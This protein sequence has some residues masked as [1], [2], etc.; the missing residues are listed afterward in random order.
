MW[1]ML[2][3]LVFKKVSASEGPDG[4]R[5]PVFRLDLY[6]YANEVTGNASNQISDPYIHNGYYSALRDFFHDLF[7]KILFLFPSF[8]DA[9]YHL[10]TMLNLILLFLFS[11]AVASLLVSIM[12]LL[13]NSMYILL[14]LVGL[15]VVIY[16]SITKRCV[17]LDV[18]QKQS[19]ADSQ[20]HAQCLNAACVS[21]YAVLT[22]VGVTL[23]S[24]STGI[25]YL[26]ALLGVSEIALN[27]ASHRWFLPKTDRLAVEC[28]K[29]SPNVKRF[30]DDI[31]NVNMDRQDEKLSSQPSR[32]DVY[33][34][35][36]ISHQPSA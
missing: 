17:A 3:T 29:S 24:M 22:Y 13:I 14:P 4:Q 10:Q 26:L 12:G 6:N 23:L 1:E 8:L 28:I 36:G 18:D 9:R 16:S 27:I 32:S 25:A 34:L 7:G 31:M 15:G 19:C 20:W 35:E 33:E 21:A 5:I 2:T 30:C 11:S